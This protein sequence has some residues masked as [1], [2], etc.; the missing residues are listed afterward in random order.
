MDGVS[1]G[2][3]AEG[4][5]RL[6]APM[7]GLVRKHPRYGYRR[8]WNLL[9]REGFAVNRKRIYGLWKKEGYKVPEIGTSVAVWATSENS[10][11]RH[12]PAYP[13]HVW[14]WDFIFDRDERGR[15]LKWLT[16]IDEFTRECLVLLPERHL[17]SLDVIDR[18]HPAYEP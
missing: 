8:I 5:P 10:C 3:P 12:Q 18:A 2:T 13:N 4:E 6:L 1:C 15:S 16:V 11:L 7:E 14:A 9:R 17:T